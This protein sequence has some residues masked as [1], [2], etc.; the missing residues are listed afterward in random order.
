MEHRCRNCYCT[1]DPRR[2]KI[3]E[4]V[5]CGDN[6]CGSCAEQFRTCINSAVEMRATQAAGERA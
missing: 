6:L 3:R 1:L 5:R 2:D 4:C